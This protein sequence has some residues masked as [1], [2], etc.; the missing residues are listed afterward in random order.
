MNN[1][2]FG[3]MRIFHNFYFYIKDDTR[4]CKKPF[5]IFNLRAPKHL[6]KMIK[7]SMEILEQEL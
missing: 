6:I 7:L 4:S 1:N 2:N 5:F 3:I